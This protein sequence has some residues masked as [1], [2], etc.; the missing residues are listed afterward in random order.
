M[1]CLLVQGDF[2]NGVSVAFFITNVDDSKRC[3]RFI[4]AVF[5]VNCYLFKY[6]INNWVRAL[7]ER[8]KHASYPSSVPYSDLGEVQAAEL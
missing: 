4:E 2:G 5:Q 1:L 3:A 6:F 7:V 8:L